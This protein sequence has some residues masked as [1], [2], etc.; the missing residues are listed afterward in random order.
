MYVPLRRAASQKGSA[1]LMCEIAN[2]S[3][4][5]DEIFFMGNAMNT[6]ILAVHKQPKGG[7]P[8][9]WMAS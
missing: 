3:M 1:F 8:F 5:I 6:I 7:L 9:E 2:R 4:I